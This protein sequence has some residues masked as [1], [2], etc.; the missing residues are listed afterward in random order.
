VI[1]VKRILFAALTTLT[2]LV[3]LLSYRTSTAGSGDT[4]PVAGAYSGDTA[5]STDG[6]DTTGGA[7]TTGGADT[8]DGTDTTDGADTTDTNDSTDGSGT[9]S[10]GTTTVTG[11]PVDTEFG[12]VQVEITVADGT[13]TDVTVLE[14]PW[15]NHHDQEINS[16]ALPILVEETLEAQSADIDMVSGAT[17]TSEGYVGS[18]QSALDEAGL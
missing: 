15:N 2:V 7:G 18:L 16:Y 10:G 3:L 5:G 11:D 6:S 14:Y 13:I 8:T 1:T 9:T 4:G 12:A 17:V